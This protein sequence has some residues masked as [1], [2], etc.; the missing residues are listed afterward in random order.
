MQPGESS[1]S[2]AS[3][4]PAGSCPRPSG[5]ARREAAA[6]ARAARLGGDLRPRG[7]GRPRPRLRQ[8][9]VHAHQRAG[10]ARL[11]HFAIDVLPVVI[12][13]ATRRANQRGLHNVRFAV[14]DA[15]TFL[16]SYVGDGFG[17]RDPPLPP[18]AVPRPAPGPPAGDDAPIPGRCP[19]GPPARRLFVVQTDNP[20][21]WHYMTRVIPAFF[22]FQDRKA[23]GPTPPR[24]G[25]AARSSPASAGCGS[26]AAWAPASTTS[27]ARPRSRWPRRCPSPA[28]APEA[29]G[30]SWT[31]GKRP[32]DDRHGQPG[33]RL[34]NAEVRQSEI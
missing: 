1:P 7:A 16:A 18:P 5:H 31:A 14:K 29:R 6:G 19:P 24:A 4:S 25:P 3:R 2:S 13:Y 26:S 22:E 32:R 30:A 11:N 15:Q 10:P 23:P 17:G 34:E 9:P 12:R 28:S 27:T 20:D 21:Y 33:H 8:R